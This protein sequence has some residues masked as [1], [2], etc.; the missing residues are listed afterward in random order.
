M[1]LDN[2]C[3]ETG[4]KRLKSMGIDANEILWRNEIVQNPNLIPNYE[5]WEYSHSSENQ[6]VDTGKIIGTHHCDY[7]EKSWVEMLGCLKRANSL[8]KE[9]ALK[10]S[11]EKLWS[12]SLDNFGG[13]FYI[14][15]DGNHR[16]TLSKFL[17]IPD[18]NVGCVAYYQF[19]QTR[20]D[21]DQMLIQRSIERV[22]I[23]NHITIVYLADVK[24]H[25]KYNSGK[26]FIEFFDRV[27]P[28]KWVK[29]KSHYFSILQDKISEYYDFENLEVDFLKKVIVAYK[30]NVMNKL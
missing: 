18:I 15:G 2:Y 17:G 30:L 14:S 10:W 5:Y 1:D 19:K 28:S 16:V 8:T 7:Y 27:N 11:K 25:I 29:F 12:I 21:F 13:A 26:E 3:L 23:D 24:I 22:Y 9:S 6:L 20:F 4:L